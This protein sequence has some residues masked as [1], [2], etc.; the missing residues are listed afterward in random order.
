MRLSRQDLK[1]ISEAYHTGGS[2]RDVLVGLLFAIA[3]FLTAYNGSSV[4][5]MV[6]SKVASAAALG[7]SLFPC[8]CGTGQEIVPYVHYVSAAIMF[9]VLA[10][11][12]VIFYRRAQAKGHREARW[13]S[14]LYAA[15]GAV[16]IIS[17][18]VLAID[19]FG[20]EPISSRI[21]RLIF[22]GER[23]G[24]VAFGASWLVASRAI[25][26]ITAPEERI[27]ILPLEV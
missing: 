26:F 6:L 2:A 9:I 20:G 25:P 15:C 10:C 24:L 21:P 5:E 17:M 23:A 16:I 12:C 27:K 13:R 8:D 3:A 7:V 11:F 4:I 18:A 14:H 19:Y 22:Y 1:S